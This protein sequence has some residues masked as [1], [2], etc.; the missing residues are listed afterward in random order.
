[1]VEYKIE[2][3]MKQNKTNYGG[4]AKMKRYDGK[5]TVRG[6]LQ[7]D[8]LFTLNGPDDSHNLKSTGKSSMLLTQQPVPKIQ[9]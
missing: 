6:A 1:M 4:T 9:K 2:H 3:Q 5:W 8:G 7:H